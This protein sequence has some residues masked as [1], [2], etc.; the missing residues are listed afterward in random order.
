MKEKTNKPNVLAIKIDGTSY[1]SCHTLDLRQ[2]KQ[3]K[4]AKSNAPVL[5]IAKTRRNRSVIKELLLFS[6]IKAI[7]FLPLKLL[8]FFKKLFFKIVEKELSGLSYLRIEVFGK[9]FIK[10]IQQREFVKLNFNPPQY[11]QKGILAFA[12]LAFLFVIPIKVFSS[13]E[14]LQGDKDMVIQ[15]GLSAYESLKNSDFASASISFSSAKKTIDDL[16]L[17]FKYLATAI[18]GVGDKL[19]FGNALLLVGENF[20]D[21]ASLLQN[22]V[23]YFD[24]DVV[25]VEKIKYLQSKVA[26]ATPHL[27]VAN[28]ILENLDND[29]S[30]LPIDINPLK[31][32]LIGG[33]K[34]LLVFQDFS[35]TLLDILGDKSFK[36]YLV[37][38]Q[39][40]NEIRPTGGFIGSFAI[41]DIDQ[42]EI[43]K[44][45]IP[46]GGSYD[47]QGQLREL[48][49][50]P[51]P[52]HLI[53]SAWQFQDSNW[54]PDFPA[55]ARKMMW[56]YE[57]SGG[58]SVDGVVAINASLMEELLGVIGPVEMPEYGKTMTA[59]NFVDETQ[60]LVEFE[61]DKEENKPKQVIADMAPKVL[62]NLLSMD[63]GQLSL[64][65]EVMHK[66]ILDKDVMVYS[67]N[68]DTE[69]KL[70]SFGL[71]GKLRDI[72]DYTDYLMVIDTNIAGQKTDG[73]IEKEITHIS[74]IQDDGSIVDTVK[75]VR[76]HTG[77]K[78]AVFSGVRNVN[79][80]RLYVPLGSTLL[81]AEGFKAPPA[82]LFESP[83]DGYVPDKDLQEIQGVVYVDPETGTR[84]NNEFGRTVFGNW[85]MVD[86]GQEVTLTLKY[87]LPNKIINQPVS[88]YMDSIK[89]SLNL[90]NNFFGY[91]M[92]I[93]KQSGAKNTFFKSYVTAKN[94]NILASIGDGVAMKQ[95][96]WY[97]EA[98]LSSDKYYGV[99]LGEKQ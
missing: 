56:F 91:K 46:G 73:K 60:Q 24:N 69:E 95:D 54:F 47:I 25:M 29:Y 15:Y 63:A 36:R 16:G 71:S 17:A 55:S 88:S 58:S 50:S 62:E 86:P 81:S 57:K 92:L 87:Q 4:S 35:N 14:E 98:E 89:Q 13:F 84:I 39:N 11:W 19:A 99:V 30:I 65:S 22:A 93:E 18:P 38:F 67:K 1:P 26:T 53:N 43:K 72:S 94:K 21:A 2:K 70:E 59:E 27:L 7:L 31:K 90:N 85:I 9:I 32:I 5:N 68:V 3:E 28:K 34:A 97:Y 33:T 42:G 12:T 6:L 64:F 66:A 78:G 74:E 44:I 80:L 51:E 61:Y 49:I 48:V 82:E 10:K 75:I 79:Y 77:V 40:N 23:E 37:V 20:S 41:I 45:E 52:F 83:I 76:R 8:K 96:G